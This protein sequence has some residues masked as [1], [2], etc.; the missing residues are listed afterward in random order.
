[1]DFLLA[2]FILADQKKINAPDRQTQERQPEHQIQQYAESGGPDFVGFKGLRH[3]A[4][5]FIF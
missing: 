2:P 5:N 4:L 1:M 3:Q